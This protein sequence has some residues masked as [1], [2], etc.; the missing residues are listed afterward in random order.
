MD[1]RQSRPSLHASAPLYPLEIQP[2]G[3]H[4][5]RFLEAL[6][7][8]TALALTACLLCLLCFP[9]GLSAG[10]AVIGPGDPAGRG[11]VREDSHRLLRSWA[12]RP[13]GEAY[14]S[15]IADAADLRRQ[16]AKAGQPYQ[17]WTAVGN[18]ILDPNRA[19]RT[20]RVSRVRWAF[21][22]SQGLTTMYLG[23]SN[24]GLWKYQVSSQ[25]WMPIS[26]T[27]VG[28]PAVGA[29]WVDPSNSKH[30]LIGTGDP[31]RHAGTGLYESWDGGGSWQR[32]ALPTTPASFYAI[33]ADRTNPKIILA[34]SRDG[35]YRSGDGGQSWQWV[36]T[37][38]TTDVKQ[39]PQFPKI[40]HIGVTGQG[41][42]RSVDQGKTFL[43]TSVGLPA[44][45]GR[46]SLAT[47]PAAP[48]VLYAATAQSANIGQMGGVYRSQDYGL[49]WTD[50]SP[51]TDPSWGQAF[52]TLAIAVDPTNPN[53]L[54]LGLGGFQY[55]F[56]AN[57]SNAAN[58]WVVGLEVGHADYTSFAFDAGGRYALVSNDGG[59]YS[60]DT[61]SMSVADHLNLVPELNLQEIVVE[62]GTPHGSLHAALDNDWLAL[63]GLQDNGVVRLDTW[64]DE[65]SYVV[66]GDGGEVHISN[67]DIQDL[68][69]TMGGPPYNRYRSFDHGANWSGANCVL[70]ST[71]GPS[72]LMMDPVSRSP[73][74]MFAHQGRFV[75]YAS[76]LGGCNWK[77]AN[78]NPLPPGFVVDHLE[79][80]TEVSAPVF[81][82]T[83]SGQLLGQS[84]YD[85]KLYVLDG[86]VHGPLGQMD[87]EDRTPALPQGS[88]LRDANVTADRSLQAQRQSWVY[89][90][91]ARSRPSRV[92]RSE[93]RGKTWKDVTGDLVTKLPGASYWELLAH[94]Q[95]DQILFLATDVGIYL[96]TNGGVVWKAM[97]DG[98]PAVINVTNIEIISAHSEAVELLISTKGRGFYRTIYHE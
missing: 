23:G 74:S 14:L 13:D 96:S 18:G 71:P 77:V 56:A 79:V 95:N 4:S 30:L 70:T 59:I 64:N 36:V 35:L 44:G 5:K 78:S 22:H 2:E 51:P 27:L 11:E 98:L 84:L 25:A 39:N 21:D 12:A 31:W 63:A 32:E 82:V 65:V 24:G 26:D 50:I 10:Q 37:T 91:T 9:R 66:G 34:A 62:N 15:A 17:P 7:P 42:R 8:T 92:F 58:Q 73:K 60:L 28:A 54:L 55:N 57:S 29:F 46:V 87:W 67:H 89:Y 52:H 43:S 19:H 53:R 45:V 76:S 94:P 83:G 88:Q 80:A 33:E 20:G 38:E 40:W 85:S 75:L 16:V 81:Y 3:K 61:E 49:T 68:F 48:Q 93:S 97:M 47:C 69:I 86:L 90:T 72:T 1:R 41:I 6:S